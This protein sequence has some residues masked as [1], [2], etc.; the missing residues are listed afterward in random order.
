[1]FVPTYCCRSAVYTNILPR[2]RMHL[3]THIYNMRT[4]ST[5]EADG[6]KNS[7]SLILIV[8]HIFAMVVFSQA[9]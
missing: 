1:M 5:V 9:P 8:R 7:S 4:Y 2:M 6:W 3:Q